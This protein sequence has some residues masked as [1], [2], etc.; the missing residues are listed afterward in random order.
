MGEP[1]ILQ[2]LVSLSRGSVSLLSQCVVDKFCLEDD[3][4][5][6][7]QLADLPKWDVQAM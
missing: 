3:A 5:I 6:K 1:Q 2:Y 7:D 4:K